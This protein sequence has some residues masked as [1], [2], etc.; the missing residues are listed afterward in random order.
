[1]AIVATDLVAVKRVGALVPFGLTLQ[2]E[3]C[4]GRVGIFTFFPADSIERVSFIP[5]FLAF[6]EETELA[7]QL[8]YD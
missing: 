6:F 4:K 2:G 8:L 3:K 5:D 7:F 1:M